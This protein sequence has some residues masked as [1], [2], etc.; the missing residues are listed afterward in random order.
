M[1]KREFAIIIGLMIAGFVAWEILGQFN[2]V[3]RDEIAPV[4]APELT[5]GFEEVPVTDQM[6]AYVPA[7]RAAALHAAMGEEHGLPGLPSEAGLL[8]VVGNP[9]EFFF[10]KQLEG[11]GE[12]WIMR[13]SGSELLWSTE[14]GQLLELAGAHGS[15]LFLKFI[16]EPF[17]GP[18]DAW[19]PGG[20]YGLDMFAPEVGV[21]PVHIDDET[22]SIIR[23]DIR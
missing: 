5:A 19:E 10:T 8:A 9:G 15:E 3:D 13:A 16:D 12:V 23:R 4:E 18:R 6:M 2:G 7:V 14:T 1:S 21:S 11:R 17:E 20:F 22:V